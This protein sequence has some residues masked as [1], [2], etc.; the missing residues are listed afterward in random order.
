MF[1]KFA[2]ADA[3]TSRRFEGT[4]LGLSITRQLLQLMHGSI[5]FNSVVGQGT[6]FHFELPRAASGAQAA[7]VAAVSETARCRVLIYEDQ[8]TRSA[9]TGKIPRILHVEDDIDLS[10]VIDAALAGRAEVVTAP[11]LQAAEQLLAEST[12][13]LVVL[14][15]KL[16]DG[17]GLRLLEKLP[18]VAGNSIPVVILSVTEVSRDVQQRVA[19]TLVKSR[20]SEAHIVQTILSL[21][22][23]AAA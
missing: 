20:V 2:Q 15:L 16:P 17:N 13:S 14:D 10:Q 18:T 12:F 4:G 5:G 9:Q 11:S 6:T 3:S 23:A 7:A 1:E 21:V 22:P 19:A 8:S